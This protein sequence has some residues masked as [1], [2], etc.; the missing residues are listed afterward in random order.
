MIGTT[1]AGDIETLVNRVIEQGLPPYL[2]REI[3]LVVF[4]RR[5]DGERYVG[6]VVEL[7][8]ERTFRELDRGGRCGVIEKGGAEVF[9]NTV[10]WREEGGF[11]VAW[12]RGENAHATFD[13]LGRLTD[14]PREAVEAEF[15]RKHRYVKHLVGEGIDEF[16]ELFE[17]L[18]DLQTNEAA[19]VERLSRRTADDGN[20]AEADGE[21]ETWGAGDD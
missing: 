11:E 4:P 19:T 1:H 13:S 10:L 21:A 20:S 7:L 6:E 14:S 5:V 18:A 3:D 16:G 9:W 8:D 15:R 17:L 2:L 12:D